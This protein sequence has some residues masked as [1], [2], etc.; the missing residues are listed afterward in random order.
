MSNFR[1]N[2]FVALGVSQSTLFFSIFFAFFYFLQWLERD[3]FELGDILYSQYCLMMLLII[4]FVVARRH[5]RRRRLLGFLF[6]KSFT[7]KSNKGTQTI[8]SIPI[9][10]RVR[11]KNGSR[12]TDHLMRLRKIIGSPS[13]SFALSLSICWR[14]TI[15]LTIFRL[16]D[17]L[18]ELID[19]IDF[20]PPS[21]RM[22][23]TN[24]RANEWSTV[25]QTMRFSEK[26]ER[27]AT[28]KL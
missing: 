9:S 14:F 23:R 11:S 18:D 15:S 19:W 24:E 22:N 13:G 5:H 7:Y 20:H 6:K 4:I 1:N 21:V 28:Q 16:M 17:I 12:R 25:K 27:N 26:W 3:H 10:N 2:N 8:P